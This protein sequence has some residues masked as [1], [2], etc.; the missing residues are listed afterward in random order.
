MKT[1]YAQKIKAPKRK[2]VGKKFN[3]KSAVSKYISLNNVDFMIMS[4]AEVPESIREKCQ[5]GNLETIGYGCYRH[6]CYN[7]D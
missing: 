2:L 4:S 3:F 7:I 1:L 6:P 5:D